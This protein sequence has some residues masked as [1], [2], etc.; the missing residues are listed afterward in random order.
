MFPKDLYFNTPT[1][2][3][4]Y[5]KKK[6]AK[7]PDDDIAH[8]KLNEKATKGGFIFWKICKGVYSLPYA[9]LIAQQQLLEKRLEKYGYRQSNKTPGVWKRDTRPISYTLITDGFGMKYVG[10][11]NANHCINVLEEHY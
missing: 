7:F 4:G 11:E 3:P 5:L 10:K 8:Y 9:G 6:L 1:D 2:F